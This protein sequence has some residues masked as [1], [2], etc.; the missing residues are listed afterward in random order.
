MRPPAKS[1]FSNPS[2]SLLAASLLAAACSSPKPVAEVNPPP[3]AAPAVASAAAPVVQGERA[4]QKPSPPPPPTIENT[5]M[6]EPAPVPVQA[7]PPA[8]AQTAKPAEPPPDALKQLLE[9][10]A[11]RVE[12]EQ[13]LAKLAADRDAAAAA[14][15]QREKDLLAFKNFYRAR[16]K[17]TT[18]DAEK[19]QGM[20]GEERAT[21]AE[22][23]VDAAKT[24]LDA[25]Q[26]AL[27][28]ARNNPP[29]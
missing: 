19:I 8:V 11:K 18:S 15:E 23:Q 14:V 12:Y 16:P 20:G 28:D 21:W 5:P 27:D 7:P 3:A 1:F 17:L 10:E 4:P 9:S 25:A 29:N 13:L 22:G 6:Q 26:K 24:A 2:F